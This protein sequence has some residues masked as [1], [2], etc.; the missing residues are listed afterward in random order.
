M[1]LIRDVILVGCKL[2]PR[3]SSYQGSRVPR[4]Y[5]DCMHDEWLQIIFSG[6]AGPTRPFSKYPPPMT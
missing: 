4:G 1:I 5:I 3:V 6:Y 2:L